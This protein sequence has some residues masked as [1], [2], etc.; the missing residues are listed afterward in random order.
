MSALEEKENDGCW[1]LIRFSLSKHVYFFTALR[2][3]GK[4][5]KEC[6]EMLAIIKAL[7]CTRGRTRVGLQQLTYNKLAVAALY[8]AQKYRVV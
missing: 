6:S 4:F 7:F 8:S 5:K 1:L 2:F 3:A